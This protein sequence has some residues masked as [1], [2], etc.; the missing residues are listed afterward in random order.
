VFSFGVCLWE[1]YAEGAVPYAEMTSEEAFKAVTAGHRLP[2]PSVTI[3]E[4]IVSL[5]RECMASLV[6]RRP[7]M[8]EVH[9][10]LGRHLRDLGAE[11]LTTAQAREPLAEGHV[12]LRPIA[13]PGQCMLE[14]E[15]SE[16]SAL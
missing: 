13:W 6:Q 7:T 10:R 3:P 5:I 12:V 11:P 1:I 14:D 15:E 2:R 9:S 8:A 16:E 4:C